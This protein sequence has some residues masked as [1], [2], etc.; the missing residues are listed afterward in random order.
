M[1]SQTAVVQS[2]TAEQEPQALDSMPMSR[3]QEVVQRSR[4][5]Q[6]VQH[7]P[8]TFAGADIYACTASGCYAHFDTRETLMEHLRE[9]HGASPDD[10][11]LSPTAPASSITYSSMLRLEQSSSAG[12]SE[13]NAPLNVPAVNP[14]EKT[15]IRTTPAEAIH[16]YMETHYPD[17]SSLSY[18]SPSWREHDRLYSPPSPGP[19]HLRVGNDYMVRAPFAKVA[20]ELIYE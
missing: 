19:V 16:D 4:L 20:N 8:H 3:V 6:P 1:H 11:M 10:L 14:V 13:L 9:S 18:V 12:A 7:S 2:P 17:A 15:R 5:E